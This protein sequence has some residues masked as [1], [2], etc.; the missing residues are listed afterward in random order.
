MIQMASN[1]YVYVWWWEPDEGGRWEGCR[2][3]WMDG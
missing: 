1:V 3:A 2:I